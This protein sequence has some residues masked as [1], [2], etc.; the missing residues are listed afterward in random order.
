MFA[1]KQL[2]SVRLYKLCEVFVLGAVVVLLGEIKFV[3]KVGLDQLAYSHLKISASIIRIHSVYY[4]ICSRRC[5]TF[6]LRRI[7]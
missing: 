5:E 2:P 6:Q 7:L 4:N 3:S 1:Q